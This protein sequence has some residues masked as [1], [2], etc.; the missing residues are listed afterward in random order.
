MYAIWIDFD[1]L[2]D[3]ELLFMALFTNFGRG[4]HCQWLGRFPH[5]LLFFCFFAQFRGPPN[6]AS[7]MYYTKFV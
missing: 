2:L 7:L 4:S 5:D 1:F 3:S 6:F